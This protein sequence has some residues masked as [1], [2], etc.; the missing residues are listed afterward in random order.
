MD[1][2]IPFITGIVMTASATSMTGGVHA[3]PGQT[4]TTGDA[5]SS[6]QVTN[7]INAGSSGGTSKTVIKTNTNGVEHTEEK[8]DSIPASGIIEIHVA[9]SSTSQGATSRTNVETHI[10]TNHASSS[11]ASSSLVLQT[12]LASSTLRETRGLGT[13]ITAGVSQF[14]QHI[15]T[16]WNV[17]R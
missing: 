2:L 4:I 15:F 17:F 13:R 5:Y 14:F 3:G 9:T 6:V 10:K 1:S 7:V 12:T 11:T 8:E 16:W